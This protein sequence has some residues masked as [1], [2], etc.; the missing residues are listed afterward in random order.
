M[1]MRAFSFPKYERVLNRV[2]FVNLNREG[3]KRHT[4]HFA[5]F[6]RK[7]GL[8]HSRLGITTSKRTGK[9]VTRNRT[10]RLVREFYRLH[11]AFFPSGYD[12]LISAKKEAGNLDFWKVREE[13]LGFFVDKKSGAPL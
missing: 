4:A 5:L 10:R 12:I 11:K 13:L 3:K 7:N 2:D 8:A 1:F 9:A 6:F